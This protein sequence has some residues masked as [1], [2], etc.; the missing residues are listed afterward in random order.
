MKSKTKPYLPLN[1]NE[2]DCDTRNFPEIAVMSKLGNMQVYF[3]SCADGIYFN[4]DSNGKT[5]GWLTKENE[6]ELKNVL[7][8]YKIRI[9]Y[10][11][12]YLKPLKAKISYMAFYFDKKHYAFPIIYQGKNPEFKEK[13][14]DAKQFSE[15]FYKDLTYLLNKNRLDIENS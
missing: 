15:E 8:H 4:I 6:E 10:L 11:T 2:R 5:D 12:D 14:K 9:E 13:I 7:D 1:F 3:V